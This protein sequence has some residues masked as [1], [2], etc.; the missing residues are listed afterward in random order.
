MEI[1]NT[2]LSDSKEKLMYQLNS[3]NDTNVDLEAELLK[4]DEEILILKKKE[5]VSR[6]SISHLQKDL[7]AAT[8]NLKTVRG[9]LSKSKAE[10]SIFK[11]ESAV[12]AV[13]ENIDAEIDVEGKSKDIEERMDDESDEEETSHD[14]DD[15]ADETKDS[16]LN[17]SVPPSSAESSTESSANITGVKPLKKTSEIYN[18]ESDDDTSFILKKPAEKAPAKPDE[19]EDNFTDLPADDSFLHP[20]T[21]S[22]KLGKNLVKNYAKR[23]VRDA[24]PPPRPL[25]S[26][27]SN[28]NTVTVF[29]QRISFQAVRNSAKA[30]HDAKEY[31]SK[32]CG[33][34]PYCSNKWSGGEDIGLVYVL[35]PDFHPSYDDT[36][37]V[38]WGHVEAS[39][40]GMEVQTQ[41]KVPV[42]STPKNNKPRRTS[43]KLINAPVKKTSKKTRLEDEFKPSDTEEGAEK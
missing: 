7:L 30:P 17:Q 5:K 34:H 19:E 39:L 41:E 20:P 38:C 26:N 4:K 27:C 13:T 40:S 21:S 32:A 6:K 29:N 11:E 23:S 9:D 18:E 35:S 3:L 10:L 2:K 14:S 43:S 31:G 42:S 1:K 33:L 28:N 16:T 12:E 8:S 37:W 15:T 24:A 25:R 22:F 36:C